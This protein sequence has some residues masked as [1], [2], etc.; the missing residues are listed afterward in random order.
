M[1]SSQILYPNF[2]IQDQVLVLAQVE[3]F[4]WKNGVNQESRKD[5]PRPEILKT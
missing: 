4:I 3:T 1:V 2:Q 5:L